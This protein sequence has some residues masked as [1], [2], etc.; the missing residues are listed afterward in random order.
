MHDLTVQRYAGDVD[1]LALGWLN[2]GRYPF[3]LQ[4]AAQGPGAQFDILFACP[5]ETLTLSADGQL[6]GPGAGPG[7]FLDSFDRWWRDEQHTD[8]VN[9]RLPFRGGWF[10]YLG[11]ELAQEI[12]PGLTLSRQDQL[13]IAF[14]TRIPVAVLRDHAA[15]RIDVIAETDH[16]HQ[17]DTVIAD[18]DRAAAMPTYR[19]TPAPVT[20]VTEDDPQI[21]LDAIAQA[22]QYIAAGDIFQANL[23]RRWHAH[24]KQAVEPADLYARLR[25]TNPGPFSALVQHSDMT[26]ISSSPERLVRRTGRQVETRPIAGTRPRN[27]SADDIEAT[28]QALLDSQKDRAEHVMLIDL[29]RNDLGRVCKGGTVEVS[30]FMVVESYSHVHHIVSNVRGEAREDLTPGDLIRAVFPGGTITGCPK[31]RCMEIIQELE[32]RARSAYTGSIGYVNHNGDCDFNILIRTMLLVN[33][34]IEVD[35]GS[36]IVADSDPDSELE[37]TRAKAKGL[38]LALQDQ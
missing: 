16:A 32:G 1:L 28:R 20:A 31:V 8:P 33:G 22:K 17:I 3:L 5:Q 15:N 29:E 35:A 12:E 30:E 26:L 4:S 27:D 37:E 36:G 25:E 24:L 21:Y 34:Q 6:S 7:G 38:L 13:P 23:S 11:Y 18:L 2:P 14:A 19:P 10:V 9:A